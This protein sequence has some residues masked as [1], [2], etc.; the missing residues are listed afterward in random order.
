MTDPIV[1]IEAA[2][3]RLGAEHEPPMGWEARVLAATVDRKPRRWLRWWLVPIP[4]AVLAVGLVVV[5]SRP[6]LSRPELAVAFTR[7]SAYRGPSM[8]VGDVMTVAVRRGGPHRAIWIYRDDRLVLACPRDPGCKGSGD[9]LVAELPVRSV[10]AYMIVALASSAAIDA[11]AGSYD[12]D[13]AGA[14]KTGAMI[15]RDRVNVH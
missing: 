7:A 5:G 12:E 2:L 6:T 14:E 15:A 13:V 3:S 10:G 4:L 1:R 11:P 8:I 9:E